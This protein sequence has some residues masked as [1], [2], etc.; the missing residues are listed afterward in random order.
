MVNFIVKNATPRFERVY[1][2]FSEADIER[3]RNMHELSLK[4]APSTAPNPDACWPMGGD[5]YR[6]DYFEYCHEGATHLYEVKT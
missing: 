1:L 4:L 5:G 2:E 6:C 3:W